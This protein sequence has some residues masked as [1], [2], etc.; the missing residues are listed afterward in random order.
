MRSQSNTLIPFTFILHILVGCNNFHNTLNESKDEVLD[1]PRDSPCKTF[2]NDALPELAW[3]SEFIQNDLAAS[4]NPIVYDNFIIISRSADFNPPDEL[5]CFNHRN[6]NKEW[7]WFD[8]F[9]NG[10]MVFDG[11]YHLMNNN[12]FLCTW[13]S[14]YVINLLDGTT[15]L[16][17]N[18]GSHEI[19][20]TFGS[21]KFVSITYSSP[22]S[23]VAALYNK[24]TQEVTKIM[25]YPKSSD[26]KGSFSVPFIHENSL[27]FSFNAYHF[28][29]KTNSSLLCKADLIGDSSIIRW[30]KEFP[31]KGTLGNWG[32]ATM[33][34]RLYVIERKLY[35]INMEDGSILWEQPDIYGG[36]AGLIIADNK[37]IVGSNHYNPS[38]YA[39]DL[40]TGEILWKEPIS[41]TASP[42]QYHSCVVYTV[43]GGD[44]LLHAVDVSTGRHLYTMASPDLAQNDYLF[45]DN[46]TVDPATNSIFLTNFKY[47]LKYQLPEY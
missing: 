40:F 46:C 44:G 23:K 15:K 4:I 2:G 28:T 16:R 21:D 10:E 13:G 26:Y 1:S 43:G 45:F 18:F 27:Y 22:S 35:C 25:E 34:N 39:F 11:P 38:L 8:Y 7:E 47:L 30:K 31:G 12:F 24:L 33:D 5:I 32:Y 17:E 3:K 14:M 42:L 19:T 41:G 20:G 37:L 29:S 6:G 36:P 9:T